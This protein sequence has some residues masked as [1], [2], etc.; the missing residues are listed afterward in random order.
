MTSD[1]AT[2]VNPLWLPS[3]GGY[4]FNRIL[5]VAR[6][7]LE[8]MDLSTGRVIEVIGQ[9]ED[10]SVSADGRY[11]TYKTDVKGNLDLWYIDTE[12]STL[13]PHP[14]LRTPALE[15]NAALAPNG[16]WFAYSVG[17]SR[18]EQVFLR[19]FPDA[20]DPIQVSIDGGQVPLLAPIG[21]G[22]IL[23]E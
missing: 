22:A 3:R 1:S 5:G 16:K 9:G 13:T 11:I 23:R 17:T 20:R 21:N 14:L 7:S 12:D 8:V 2:E 15:G 10:H 18:S 4:L 6:G 19:R